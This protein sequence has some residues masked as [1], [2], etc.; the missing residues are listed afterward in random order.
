MMYCFKLNRR[1]RSRKGRIEERGT[2]ERKKGRRIRKEST[3]GK[4]KER[5][6]REGTE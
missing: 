3:R 4:R 6:E 5:M 2:G 1:I